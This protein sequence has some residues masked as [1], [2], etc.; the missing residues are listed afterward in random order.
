M[1]CGKAFQILG[2]NV[3]RLLSLKLA[4]LRVF[5]KISLGLTQAFGFARNILFMELGFRSFI[6][7]NISKAK[8]LIL[9][10]SIYGFWLSFSSV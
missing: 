1:F 9:F 2:P 4:D 6:F 8:F 3:A 7:L 10:I 5:T